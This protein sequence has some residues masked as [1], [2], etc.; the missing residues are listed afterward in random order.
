MARRNGV[1]RVLPKTK[2]AQLIHYLDN[3]SA[4]N[5]QF[6]AAARQVETGA[7]SAYDRGLQREIYKP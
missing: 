2:E 7:F 4:K 1:R 3:I 5:D 6:T